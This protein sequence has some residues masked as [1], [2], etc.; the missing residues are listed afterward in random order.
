MA[1][2]SALRRENIRHYVVAV[3]VVGAVNK[4]ARSEE[5]SPPLASDWL[6]LIS[7]R[8]MIVGIAG[9]VSFAGHPS[10]YPRVTAASDYLV[11]TGGQATDIVVW[12]ALSK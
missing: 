3:A 11:P 12:P 8:T 2:M 4:K 5:Y 7:S 10:R 1:R 9:V 6:L